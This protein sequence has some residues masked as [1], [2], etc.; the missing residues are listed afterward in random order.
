MHTFLDKP[1]VLSLNR[2]WQVIGHRTVKQA[3]VALTGGDATAAAAL[4][5]PSA[6]TS[7]TRHSPLGA[8]SF[9]SAQPPR[10]ILTLPETKPARQRQP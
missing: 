9:H 10:R 6:S 5:P 7:P 4:P 2:S 8:P 3:L 1:L